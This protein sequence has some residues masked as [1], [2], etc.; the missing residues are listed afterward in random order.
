ML[1]VKKF[2][3]FFSESGRE[4]IEI[5]W[6]LEIF[7][8]ILNCLYDSPLRL[9]VTSDNFLLLFEVNKFNFLLCASFDP[10]VFL[11]FIHLVI[12]FCLILK[13]FKLFDIVEEKLHFMTWRLNVYYF[14]LS[15]HIQCFVK[16]ILFFWKYCV[17]FALQGA[18]YFGVEMLL[19]RCKTWFSEVVSAE[20]Q[21][22]IQLDDLTSIWSFGVEHGEN[23]L[24]MKI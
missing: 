10:M 4:C 8:S 9:E 3:F 16:L 11:S 6:N 24:N 19:V 21:P 18:L 1:P 17:A 13:L 15:N 5:E 22:Q 2:E 23:D 12:C 14:H 7:L 20:V